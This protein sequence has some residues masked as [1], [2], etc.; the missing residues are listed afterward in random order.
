MYY[1][2]STLKLYINISYT[3]MVDLETF[4]VTV[5]VFYLFNLNYNNIL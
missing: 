5:S 2:A 4:G 3:S 1:A